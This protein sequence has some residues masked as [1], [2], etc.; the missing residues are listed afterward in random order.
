MTVEVRIPERDA[1]R[2]ATVIGVAAAAL[3]AGLALAW[4]GTSSE[5]ASRDDRAREAARDEGEGAP[6]RAD[7]PGSAEAGSEAAGEPA[8]DPSAADDPPGGGA[9]SGEPAAERAAGDEGPGSDARGAP[10]E[11]APEAPGSSETFA[12]AGADAAGPNEDGAEPAGADEAEAD[13]ARADETGADEAGAGAGGGPS[14]GAPEP[15]APAPSGRSVRRGRVAYLRCVGVERR[16][17][18]F[19]CPRDEALEAA[20]WPVIDRLTACSDPPRTAGR[21]DVRLDYAG[22]GPPEVQWRDTFADDVVRLD[23]ERVLGCLAEGLAETRQTLGAERLLVSFR[24][25]LE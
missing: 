24:F 8:G 11:G 17:G 21:A 1:P 19:P 23:R 2:P 25:R 6:G 9:R 22:E 12:A 13:E 10:D 14:G 15:A 5:A 18:R 3:L 16:G 7:E 20:V 4:A